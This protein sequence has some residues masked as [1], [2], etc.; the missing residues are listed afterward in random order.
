MSKGFASNYRMVVLATGLFL[1]FGGLVA[2]LVDLHVLDRPRLLKYVEQARRVFTVEHARRG[3][4]CD[5]NGEILAT[6]RSM[7]NVGLDPQ[8][9][10]PGDEARWPELARLLG[11][12]VA[13]IRAAARDRVYDPP[14]AGPDDPRPVQWVKL[15]GGIDESVYDQ[16]MAL[17]IRGV[18]GNR[19]FHRFYPYN[20]LAA[21]VIG[22][23][24]H[25]GVP[26]AGV[27]RCMNFYLRGINGWRETE[28][29]G[30]R[31][32]MAQ[33]E[34]RDV[35]PVDGDN[36][37]LTI[38][39]VV[40]H[41]I[42]A[43]LQRLADRYAPKKATIIVTDARNGDILGLANY[44]TF[45]PNE[46]NRVP[47][48]D[49]RD[50]AVTDV[51][52]PGSVFKI[53]A[54]SGAL[55][56]H[57]VT[58]GSAFDCSLSQIEYQGHMVS[59]PHDDVPHQTLTVAQILSVSSNR[60]AA[61]LAML[62]GDQRYYDYVRAFGF[63][64][65]TGFPLGGEVDGILAPPKDWSR[66]TI[67]RMPMGQGIAVTPMQIQYAMGAIA[68]GGVLLQPQIFRNVRDPSGRVIFRFKELPRR[69]VMSEHTARLM[70]R[71]LMG[72]VTDQGTAPEAAIPGYQV[73]G[74]TGTSQKV[75]DGHYSNRHSVA[76]FVGFFPASQPRVVISVIVDDADARCPGGHAWGGTVA[77]PAFKN[78]AEQLIQYLDIKSVSEPS[79]MQLAMDDPAPGGGR[80]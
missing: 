60:G 45:N 39:I 77:A 49:L 1:S 61:Q 30:R 29:D 54:V 26:A 8:V 67:T 58:P 43:E 78:I 52:E 72:V 34:T 80:R 23:V 27:E 25:D 28:R 24:T 7:L 22:F 73:A 2:R 51:Y 3:N 37:T 36:V 68:D 65:K 69:R 11:I 35:P 47:L 46:Y 33:F 4:I 40:Q 17:K 44:P 38:D 12:T 63:G 57:L 20:S 75:I 5:T 18:Y 74:K 55:N 56:S 32:E 21:D 41:I 9:L 42:E 6:S 79:P 48:R 15:A 59:L 16:V 10:R 19:S 71:L 66:I 70:A 64:Q 76:S 62:L 14:G 13:D 50:F 53:V 31:H